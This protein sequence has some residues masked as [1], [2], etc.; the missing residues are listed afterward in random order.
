MGRT[1][2]SAAGADGAPNLEELFSMA[3]DAAKK[4]QRQGAR[5]MF[6][7]ILEHDRR[8]IRA[9]MYLAKLAPN[10]KE[11][12]AW[13]EKVLEIRPGYEPAEE[14][15]AKVQYNRQAER[16]RVLFRVGIGAYVVVVLL[17]TLAVI[18]SAATLTV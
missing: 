8:N 12:L 6:R 15:L 14:M 2:R 18:L 16:N 5:V 1:K 4:G 7:Q 11:R 10:D 9:M 13:L 17:I 3:V